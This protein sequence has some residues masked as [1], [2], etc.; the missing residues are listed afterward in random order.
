MYR[1]QVEFSGGV[2][3]LGD[4]DILYYNAD[5]INDNSLTK[6]GLGLDPPVRFQETR[7]TALLN[8]ISKF[9][10]SIVRFTMNGPNKDLPVFI[11]SIQIGQADL[12]LTSYSVG[13]QLTKQVLIGGNP[14]TF[15][16]YARRFVEYQSESA[17]AYTANGVV[18]PNP[19]LVQQDIRGPYYFVYT[20]QHWLDLMNETLALTLTSA[21]PISAFKPTLSLQ[22]QFQ[23]FWTANGGAGAAPNIITEAP[24]IIYNSSSNLFTL[25]GDTYGFGGADA[26]SFGTGAAGN[27]E[28]MK[29]WFNTNT[30]GLFANFNNTYLGDEANGQVNQIIFQNK[31]GTNIY[32]SQSPTMAVGPPIQPVFTGKSYYQEVQ[33]YESTSSLWSP[34]TSIVF[35]STLIPIYPEQ[36]GAPIVYGEGN[37]TAN[38][39]STNAFQPIITDIAL[40]LDNAA[41]Y[42]GFIEYVPS[43]EYRMSAFTSSRQELRNIDVQVFWKARLDGNLYPLRLFNLSSVSIKIMF[44]KKAS[45]Q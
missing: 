15:N 28:A 13:L 5:I 7:S 44:R 38:N 14:F 31:L 33:D 1:S 12:D 8:D 35:T 18:L 21:D 30:F 17:P 36:V 10:F 24:T 40:P 39:N 34:I 3:P 27:E 37:D 11:P 20:Y 41:N 42:R 32:Y 6:V 25:N 2:D 9:Y 26:R 29:L 43:A 4:P 19:P 16:G 22:E 23:A 45:G